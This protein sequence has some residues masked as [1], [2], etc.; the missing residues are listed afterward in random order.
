MWAS[1]TPTPSTQSGN[2]LQHGEVWSV[3]AVAH[4]L[5]R[6]RNNK[7]IEVMTAPSVIAPP[8][9][10]ADIGTS[11]YWLSM[12]PRMSED[13]VAFDIDLNVEASKGSKAFTGSGEAGP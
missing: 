7:G 12:T 1:R 11:D 3:E 6:V 4:F 10:K 5:G 9:E 13:G 2:T 8:G